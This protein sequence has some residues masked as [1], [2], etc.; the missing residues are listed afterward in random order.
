MSVLS[1]HNTNGIFFPIRA[2]KSFD[3]AI[4]AVV[5]NTVYIVITFIDELH[6]K[7]CNFSGDSIDNSS[8]MYSPL[9]TH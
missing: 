2:Q 8:D 3:S 1:G 4:F 5:C 9:R 7:R 6:V